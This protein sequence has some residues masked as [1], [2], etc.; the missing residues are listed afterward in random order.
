MIKKYNNGWD[1][2]VKYA[3]KAYSADMYWTE[4]VQTILSLVLS[5]PS[6][7][8]DIYILYLSTTGLVGYIL[9]IY[10]FTE[11]LCDFKDDCKIVYLFNFDKIVFGIPTWL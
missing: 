11:K 6:Q 1:R 7:Y 8:K 3:A 9:L 10:R 2:R 5:L 4:C